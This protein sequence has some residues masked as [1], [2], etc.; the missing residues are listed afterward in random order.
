MTKVNVNENCIGCG[1]CVGVAPDIFDL[2]DDGL[3]QT[4]D[5]DFE[6][7][8]SVAQEAVDCCPVDAI[9]LQ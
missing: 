2:N 7:L 1:A 4:K 5:Y 9:E 8:Q 6:N 3:A